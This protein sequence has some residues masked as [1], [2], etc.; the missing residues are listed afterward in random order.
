MKT[1]YLT[2]SFVAAIYLSLN[3][4]T[5]ISFDAPIE[6]YF[7]GT[8]K[9]YVF[10][11][12]SKDRKTLIL[13]AIKKTKATNIFVKTKS[14]QFVFSLN[15][16]KKSSGNLHIKRAKRNDSYQLLKREAT[17]ALYKGKTSLLKVYKD[18]GE[19]FLSKIP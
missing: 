8:S 2:K 4:L 3:S 11:A 16:R 15:F 1:W 17:F 6:S 5:V 7:L 19:E 12:L 18:G 9:E 14:D 13:K 10:S